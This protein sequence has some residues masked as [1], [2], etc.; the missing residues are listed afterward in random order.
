M[1]NH[2]E[3]I[4]SKYRV[5]LRNS[6]IEPATIRYIETILDNNL[7]AYIDVLKIYRDILSKI[8]GK[9]KSNIKKDFSKPNALHSRRK[10]FSA[11][12]TC[13]KIMSLCILEDIGDIG[14]YSND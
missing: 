12:Y 3:Y 10:T 4:P 7:E 11:N 6:N 2:I 14:D 5:D 9:T 8:S 1:T 13:S